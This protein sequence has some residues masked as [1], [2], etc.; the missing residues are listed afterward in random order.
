MEVISSLGNLTLG[1]EDIP[2]TTHYELDNVKCFEN[3]DSVTGKLVLSNL[4]VI[5]PLS[6]SH[7]QES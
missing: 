5:L 6:L 2:E 1:E 3:S 7:E 4:Y